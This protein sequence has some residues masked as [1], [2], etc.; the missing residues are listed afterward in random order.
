MVRK[1]LNTFVGNLAR[2]FICGNMISHYDYKWDVGMEI[3][4]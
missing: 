4:R 1:M 3:Q 2:R